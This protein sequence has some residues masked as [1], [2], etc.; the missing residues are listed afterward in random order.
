[1]TAAGAYWS[2]AFEIT[3]PLR[4]AAESWIESPSGPVRGS[5]EGA[6]QSREAGVITRG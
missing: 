3:S 1:M 6:F 4:M 2:G 5:T